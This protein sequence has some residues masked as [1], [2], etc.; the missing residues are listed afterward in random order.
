VGETVNY[1]P[2]G[3]GEA[4]EGVHCAE[5]G[6]GGEGGEWEVG[7]ERGGGW[8]GGCVRGRAEGEG[9]NYVVEAEGLRC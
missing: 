2:E 8:E 3:G 5:G 7:R 9:G 1:G 6:G 4:K